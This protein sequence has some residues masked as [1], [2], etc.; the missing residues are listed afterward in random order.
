MACLEG[1]SRAPHGASNSSANF[2]TAGFRAILVLS[3]LPFDRVRVVGAAPSRPAF[4]FAGRISFL[5][6]Q[7]Q[8]RQSRSAPV[9]PR[10]PV[11][12]CSRA[13]CASLSPSWRTRLEGANVALAGIGALRAKWWRWGYGRQRSGAG[14]PKSLKQE[15]RIEET[16]AAMTSPRPKTQGRLRNGQKSGG[17]GK[18][19]LS[20]KLP[21]L[22]ARDRSLATQP[23]SPRSHCVKIRTCH[24]SARDSRA[25]RTGFCRGRKQSLAIRATPR[26]SHAWLPAVLSIVP[27]DSQGTALC[28]RIR[29]EPVLVSIFAAQTPLCSALAAC[30]EADLAWGTMSGAVTPEQWVS[31]ERLMLGALVGS[32]YVEDSGQ[33]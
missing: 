13:Q 28:H 4:I 32:V 24:L 5:R 20:R 21:E 10:H 30:R 14:A 26:L 29:P 16:P 15:R 3:T 6:F 17:R 25:I 8:L 2:A 1:D 11:P 9:L 12:S 23:C 31:E 22:G 27:R 19:N 33:P 18:K 7:Q